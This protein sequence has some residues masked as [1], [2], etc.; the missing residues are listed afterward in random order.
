MSERKGSGCQLVVLVALILVGGLL[1]L[2]SQPATPPREKTPEEIAAA[3]AKAQKK[4]DSSRKGTALLLAEDAIRGKLKAPSTAQFSSVNNTKVA[5][6]KPDWWL[7]EGYVDSQNDFGAMLR[8]RYSVAI[9][10]Q[11]GSSDS[12]RIL[13][14]RIE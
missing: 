8:A 10:F 7:V 9:E 13:S 2:C 5:Q 4:L 6:V 12:Y 1:A 14:A 11:E 3:Q